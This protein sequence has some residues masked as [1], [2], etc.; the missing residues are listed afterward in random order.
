MLLIATTSVTSSAQAPPA[1]RYPD[2]PPCPVPS[3]QWG[4]PAGTLRHAPQERTPMMTTDTTRP[5]RRSID[6]IIIAMLP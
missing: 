6:V 2:P 1:G 3:G 4:V 5:T